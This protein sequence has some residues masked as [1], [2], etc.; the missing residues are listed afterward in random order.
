MTKPNKLVAAVG[1]CT[2]LAFTTACAG[3][4]RREICDEA[5]KVF[6]EYSAK[7]S[8]AAGDLNS[9][10]KVMTDFS[11]ELAELSSKADGEL[12]NALSKMSESFGAIDASDPKALTKATELPTKINEGTRELISACS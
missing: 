1:A 4:A 5:T 8:S 2:L 7:M 3:G 9:I 6:T 10:N 12:K 11:A